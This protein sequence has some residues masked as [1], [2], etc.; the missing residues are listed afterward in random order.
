M[1]FIIKAALLGNTRASYFLNNPSE[2]KLLA[3]MND[4]SDIIEKEI[5]K[6]ISE[7]NSRKEDLLSF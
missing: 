1:Y 4:V 3:R 7:I 6:K 5:D 2:K